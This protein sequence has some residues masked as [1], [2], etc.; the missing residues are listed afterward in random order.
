MPENKQENSDE[1][2]NCLEGALKELIEIK[3]SQPDLDAKAR[4]DLCESR[5]AEEAKKIFDIIRAHWEWTKI[6]N[7]QDD[8]V[9]CSAHLLVNA[10]SKFK[11]EWLILKMIEAY[12]LDHDLGE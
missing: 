10:I 3:T 6:N 1:L 7:P 8:L 2:F 4:R 9:N 12:M 5:T 11:K